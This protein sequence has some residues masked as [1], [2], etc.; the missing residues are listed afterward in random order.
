MKGDISHIIIRIRISIKLKTI[1]SINKE[2]KRKMKAMF[3]I[4]LLGD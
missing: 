1:M 3:I 4:L 2:D